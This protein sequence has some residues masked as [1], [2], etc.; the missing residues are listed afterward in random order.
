MSQYVQN[1]Y[2]NSLSISEFESVIIDELRDKKIDP[3]ISLWATSICSDEVNQIFSKLNTDLAGPGAFVMGG[4]SGLP[5]TGITGLM[6]Y[7]SHVPEQGA[8][9]IIFGPHIGVTKEGTI[10]KIQRNKQDSPTSCCGSLIAAVNALPNYDGNGSI[11]PLDYQQQNV[12]SSLAPFKD[13]IIGHEYPVKA[14][15]DKAYSNIEN[16]I[17]SII[18]ESKQNLKGF[19]ILLVGGILINTDFDQSDFIQIRC[20][21]FLEF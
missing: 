21:D 14:A 18:E 1:F 3:S 8:A 9:V 13:E 7:L 12:V 6:A 17:Y 2:P 16:R 20:K 11:N 10:G 5:F 19:K 15:T 4:I